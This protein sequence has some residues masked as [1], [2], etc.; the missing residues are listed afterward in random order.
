MYCG[1]THTFG[2]YAS[3][4]WFLLV[5][6]YFYSDGQSHPVLKLDYFAVAIRG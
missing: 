5:T 4:C 2:K 3:H 6:V 1:H